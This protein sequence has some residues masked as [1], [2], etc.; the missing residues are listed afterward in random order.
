MGE[1]ILNQRHPD[2]ILL[3]RLD[4]FFDRQRHFARFAGAKADVSGF[5]TNDDERC[6]RKIL[7]AFDN[8]RHAVNR[9]DLIFQIQALWSDSLLRLSH[10][11][12]FG[13]FALRFFGFASTAGAASAAGS[14]G[15]ASASTASPLFRPAARAASVNARTR[16]R[17][18]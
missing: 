6:E 4:T 3:R 7:T 18:R 8:F 11:Y 9:D 13:S 15:A 5:I 1:S 16:P 10:Y 2:Q 17:Y 12:S 14:S